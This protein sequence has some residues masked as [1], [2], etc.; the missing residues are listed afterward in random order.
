MKIRTIHL[1]DEGLPSSLKLTMTVA[2][3]AFLT[4]VI[5]RM[6]VNEITHVG[7]TQESYGELA[8]LFNRFYDGGVHDFPTPAPHEGI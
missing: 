4:R 2:E 1:D 3:A 7:M 8:G 6:N 5:G